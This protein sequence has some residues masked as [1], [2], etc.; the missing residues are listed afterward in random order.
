MLASIQHMRFYLCTGH[1]ESIGFMTA[2]VGSII[3]GLC[4]GNSAAPAGWLL[5]S[6]VLIKVYKSLGHG[7]FFQT[8]ISRESYDTAGVLYVDDINLFTMRSL[9]VTRELW[10]EV[11]SIV[12]SVGP[13]Y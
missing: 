3:Q 4:Q 9:L 1:G 10:E 11:A 6:A 13:N 2:V 8:P 7:A 5:I 12:R